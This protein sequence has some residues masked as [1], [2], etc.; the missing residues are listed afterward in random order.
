MKNGTVPPQVYG[1]LIEQVLGGAKKATKYLSD[2]CVAK[3]TFQGQRDNRQKFAMILVTVGSPNHAE[4]RFIKACKTA[5]EP[6]PVKKIQLKFA[7]KT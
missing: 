6:F 4:R 1:Q 5:G 3:A 2:K 7:P